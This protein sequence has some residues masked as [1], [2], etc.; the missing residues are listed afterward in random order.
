[1]SAGI[2]TRVREVTS[3]FMKSSLKYS[4]TLLGAHLSHDRIRKI[5][6]LADFIA[7]GRWMIDHGFQV[8]HREWRVEEVWDAVARQVADKRVLYL[9]FG[10][11]QGAS[12]RY[13][14]RALTNPQA[15][16]HGFD[17]FEG[18]PTAGG[19]W[20]RGQFDTQGAIP[21]IRDDRVRFFK[22]WFDEVLP[23]YV[24]PAHDVLV[25]NLDADLYSSTA[26]VLR[27]LRDQIKPG[28]FI[29]F[30]ELEHRE[31]EAKAFHEFM[32]ETGRGF[33]TVSAHVSLAH[34]FFECV[35]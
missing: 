28:T 18:L 21:E 17:S 12:M 32:E 16:L 23:T 25:I 20:N 19:G 10:V 6:A 9:E 29:Y 35:S 4:L 15:M 26:C 3:D 22:G 8:A 30:D 7:A 34:V 33:R 13:W 14:S 1:M 5:A 11:Y 27:A 24:P 31:H 2:V